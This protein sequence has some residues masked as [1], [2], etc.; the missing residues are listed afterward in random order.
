MVHTAS[1]TGQSWTGWLEKGYGEKAVRKVRIFPQKLML[2]KIFLESSSFFIF[3]H[4][5]NFSWSVNLGV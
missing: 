3:W 4:P 1:L 2:L 5:L